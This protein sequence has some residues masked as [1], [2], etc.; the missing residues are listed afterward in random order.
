MYDSN[1][2]YFRRSQMSVGA[3]SFFVSLYT[4]IGLLVSA[5]AVPFGISYF[6]SLTEVWQFVVASLVV[7]AIGIGAVILGTHSGNAFVAFICLM[8]LAF[9]FGAFMGPVVDQYTTESVAQVFALTSAVVILLGI[10]GAL[11][12]SSLEGM[13]SYL[14]GGLILLIVALFGVPLMAMFGLPVAGVM[15]VL[16][17]AG[18][19]IFGGFVL[20]DWNKIV[21]EA[22]RTQHG[23][24]IGAMNIY[25]DFI[26]LFLRIL[27][28]MGKKK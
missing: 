25:L 7:L 12:P 10:A 16:D 2:L 19:L 22:V 21:R 5:W 28:L 1:E 15:T 18:I 26:N 23:A 20:Y 8:V 24:V 14:M 4:F 11:W 17:W 9:T 6:G 13:G 3:Y 27:R